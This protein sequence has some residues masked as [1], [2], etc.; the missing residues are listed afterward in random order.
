MTFIDEFIT[1]KNAKDDKNINGIM[2]LNLDGQY[3]YYIP[4]KPIKVYCEDFLTDK[5]NGVFYALKTKNGE[6]KKIEINRLFKEPKDN[7]EYYWVEISK[8]EYIH[9][10]N[11]SERRLHSRAMS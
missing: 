11:E 3:H 8:E 7:E 6:Q 9:R 10:K 5:K 1:D 4:G 2:T